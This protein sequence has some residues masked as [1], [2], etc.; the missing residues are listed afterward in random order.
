MPR[1]A[2]WLVA[3]WVFDF[4]LLVLYLSFQ[5]RG[6]VVFLVFG[7]VGSIFWHS[8]RSM[9]GHTS[10]PAPAHHEDYRDYTSYNR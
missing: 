3:L 2:Q 7:L 5:T 6:I 4:A 9:L 8:F 1:C 10:N